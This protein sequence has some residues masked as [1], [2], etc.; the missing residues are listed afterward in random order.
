MNRFHNILFVADQDRA[1]TA[2][3]RQA[4]ELANS[5]D[6]E[7]TVVGIVEMSE[8]ERRSKD[9]KTRELIE[10]M[11]S[12]RRE[13]LEQL[14]EAV[15]AGNPRLK[16]EVLVGN[17]FLE[18]TREVLRNERDLVIKTVDKVD[19][20][21]QLYT[22]TDMKLLRK[23]PCPVWLIKST[24]VEGYRRII[25]GLDYS[26][27]RRDGDAM[28][29]QILQ[30]ASSLAIR[31]GAHLDVVHAWSLPHEDFMRSA[32]SGLTAGEVESLVES[33]DLSRHRWVD[34]L[35]AENAAA[36]AEREGKALEIT[37]HLPRGEAGQLIPALAES[38][39]AD[40]VV[41][42][43]VGRTGIPGLLIGNTAELVLHQIQCS[44]LAVKPQGFQTPVKL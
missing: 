30:M 36:T 24:A 18:V 32:R 34:Q 37:T 15:A 3:L 35:V 1:D 39:A 25:A 27:S 5:N 41:M 38:L 31:S 2:A 23:C 21:M 6:A 4:V 29:A 13:A 28:N 16:V 20:L 7:L 9:T 22:G 33:E 42:G 12:V 17:T 44:V 19:G 14:A 40:L 8:R 11:T 43:T 10:T 26:G